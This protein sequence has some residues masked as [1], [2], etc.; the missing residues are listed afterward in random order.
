MELRRRDDD[1]H[2]WAKI[3]LDVGGAQK[4]AATAGQQELWV[5]GLTKRERKHHET[6]HQLK[7]KQNSG[8]H[9]HLTYTRLDAFGRD[10]RDGHKPH[11]DGRTAMRTGRLVRKANKTTTL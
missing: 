3:R 2:L 4:T 8:T 5:D 7:R 6:E 10:R 11:A 1:S 9:G